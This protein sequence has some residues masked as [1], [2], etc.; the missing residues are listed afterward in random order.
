MKVLDVYS[1]LVRINRNKHTVNF[2]LPASFWL[3]LASYAGDASELTSVSD[4]Y[5]AWATGYCTRVSIFNTGDITLVPEELRFNLPPDTTI[6]SSWGGKFMRDG[7]SVIVQYP[8]PTGSIQPGTSQKPS[9]FCTLGTSR[10]NNMTTLGKTTT[11]VDAQNYAWQDGYENEIWQQNWGLEFDQDSNHQIIGNDVL[12]GNKAALVTYPEGSYGNTGGALYRLS[13]NLLSPEVPAS[14]SMYVRYYV[15]FA[16]DFD[17]TRGGKLPGFIGGTAN[18]GGRKP[19][20]YDG[21]S[22]RMTWRSNGRIVQ[23]V[24][25]P[26][27]QGS[28]GEN[29]YWNENG[30]PRFFTPGQWHCVESYLQMNNVVNESGLH[31][32]VVRSWLDGE[33]ALNRTDLRFRHTDALRIDGFYFSTFFGGNDDTW[34]PSKNES[35]MFDEFVIDNQRIGC[36]TDIDIP[37]AT[38][39]ESSTAS[40]A[41]VDSILIFNADDSGWEYVDWNVANSTKIF[42]DAR[43]NHTTGGSKSL[44]I[45]FSD[46]AHDG[47]R[48]IAEQ[49]FD[50]NRYTHVR[51]HV[52]P[53]GPG[54][55]FRIRFRDAPDSEDVVVDASPTF[56]D[57]SWNP[58]VWQEVII[59]ISKF[60]SASSQSSFLLHADN[61]S[62]S[63]AFWIDDIELV[64]LE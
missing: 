55:A 3:S 18:T 16:D 57:G 23:Y 31:D 51:I 15:K 38:S 36:R 56:H 13:F 6:I 64:T 26:D 27:Q 11:N 4:V 42:D 47:V 39:A 17:F 25:H 7:G 62:G 28:F 1:A 37:A 24:Y 33:L 58:G 35:A 59:P 34:A 32:G 8:V 45:Q 61:L 60:N 2:L 14:N 19:N 10:P 22:A 20:G 40:G 49:N 53:V 9:G 48:F 50:P 43:Q 12:F 21:F 30:V 52:M 46:S 41:V 5:Y 54:T 63:D 29:I 44:Y